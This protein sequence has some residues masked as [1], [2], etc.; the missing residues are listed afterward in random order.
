MNEKTGKSG[1][2]PA[3]YVKVKEEEEEEEEE[4]AG[5]GVIPSPVNN[6][7]SGLFGKSYTF[8]RSRVADIFISSGVVQL[9][10]GW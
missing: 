5:D 3:T 2:V 7:G 1:L 6:Q 4:V 8:C 9:R 10:C